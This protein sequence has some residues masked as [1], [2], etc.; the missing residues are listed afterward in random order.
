MQRSPQASSF[1]FPAT[2]GAALLAA[3]LGAACTEGGSDGIIFESRNTTV[4]AASTSLVRVSER[5]LL[6]QADENTTGDGGSFLNDDDDKLDLVAFVV[7]MASRK[8]TNLRL[9]VDDFAILGTGTVAQLFAVVSEAQDGQDWD[10]DQVEDDVVLL[11]VPAGSAGVAKPALVATLA[12]PDARLVVSGQRLYFVEDESAGADLLAGESAINVIELDGQS[13]VV[14]PERVLH[15]IA[16]PVSGDLL[17]DVLAEPDLVGADGGLL[18][19]TM[20]ETIEVPAGGSEPGVNLNGGL[21]KLEDTDLLDEHV[22]GVLDTTDP[23][24][25]AL[26]LSLCVASD[27]V[28]VR[29]IDTGTTQ[30]PDKLVAFLVS[31]AGQGEINLNVTGAPDLPG[32]WSPTQ[33]TTPDADTTD[34]VLFSLEWEAWLSDPTARARNTG[35]AGKDRVLALENGSKRF[36][37]TLS[38]EVDAGCDLNGDTDSEDKVFRYAPVGS[39][40][41][42]V[43]SAQALLAIEDVAGGVQGV[44]DLSERFVAVISEADNQEDFDDDGD[45]DHDLVAW[46][47]PGAV[48]NSTAAPWV[49]DHSP[50]PGIQAAGCD[51]MAE[52]PQRDRLDLTYQEAVH[53]APINTGGDSDELDSIP[54]FARFDP[55]DDLDFPGPPVAGRAKNAGIA[56]T[57]ND[58]GL[59]RVD[60]NAD[61]RDWN[62]DGDKEDMVLFR[63]TVSTLQNS[64]FLGVLNDLPR[65]A[66]EVG[67]KNGAAYLADEAM[68]GADFNADGDKEDLVV[69]WFRIG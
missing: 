20:D 68:A 55:I 30:A 46:L 40:T 12:G 38:S 48:T 58:I 50:N 69:R 57:D 5:W 2:L 15:A 62:G 25:L 16:D 22:L 43:T 47:N 49:F 4:S 11:R 41:A 9:A 18:F 10:G 29:A 27:S 17:V 54:S 8:E 44:T 31:E 67:G 21:V 13:Q 64:N 7:D 53:G 45:T 24:G 37:A 35:L 6:F 14:G 59:Y 66:A 34:T 51:W 42:F 32:G 3:A 63:T 33:C 26:G 52:R 28:P 36:V 1:P 23:A 60:E 39:G 61:S 19:F 56:L 65:P